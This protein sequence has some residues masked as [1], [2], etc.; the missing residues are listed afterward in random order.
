MQSWIF[1][2]ASIAIAWSWSFAA[3]AQPPKPVA[4]S[5]ASGATPKSPTPPITE[6][7]LLVDGVFLTTGG[8]RVTQIDP[9]GPA[10]WMWDA[11]RNR[12]VMEKD[13]VIVAVD[14]KPIHSEEEYFKAINDGAARNGTVTLRIIDGRSGTPRDWTARPTRVC[15]VDAPASVTP[16]A[17]RAR[18][19]KALLLGDTEDPQIGQTV[20]VDLASVRLLLRGMP[21]LATED[22]QEL[23]GRDFTTAN[24]LTRV[25]QLDVRPNDCLFCYISAHGAYSKLKADPT[26]PSGGHFIACAAE[27]LMRKTL[28]DQLKGKRAQ[29]TVLISDAC[30]VNADPDRAEFHRSMAVPRGDNWVLANLFLDHT[31]V[32]DI[33][34]SAKDQFAWSSVDLGGWFTNAFCQ[35]CYPEQYQDVPFVTWDVAVARVAEVTNKTFQSRR[36]QA[37]Q[38]LAMTPEI[39]EIETIFTMHRE[40]RPQVFVKDV[41]RIR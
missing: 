11:R 38:R 23:S 5:G 30:N 37:L 36:A 29:L 35:N 19:V 31:G 3:S 32:I 2:A 28:L 34:A 22:I 18:A 33:N 9:S 17:R 8:F 7:R 6:Y 13:D 41:Q 10:A 4:P 40:Q 25:R 27:E 1:I 26:D 14:G 21:H 16:S 39:E 12:G 24:V 20:R 15:N